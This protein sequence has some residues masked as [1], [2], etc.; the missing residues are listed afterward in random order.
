MTSYS[1]RLLTPIEEQEI[2]P[3]RRVWVS[4]AVEL[5]IVFIIAAALYVATALLGVSLPR[6]FY[7]PFNIALL[8]LPLALWTIFSLL[9]ER[10]AAEP[11]QHLLGVLVIGGLVANA[12]GYPVVTQVFQTE[13]WL[14]L[15]NAFT[16]IVGYTV[17]IGAFQEVLKYL[18][19]RYSIWPQQF[20]TRLDGVAYAAACALGYASVLNLQF[21][22]NNA[23]E[24]AIFAMRVFE[25]I[26]LHTAGAVIVS[27]G[28]SEMRFSTPSPLIL[29]LTVVFAAVINGAYIPLSA[30]LS[31]AGFSLEGSFASPVF[32]FALAGILVG[33]VCFL[34]AFL[35]TRSERQAIEAEGRD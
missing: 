25:N 7:L 11:R 2:Y 21:L 6:A 28:L 23:P 19:I 34:T 20:R 27:F 15:A 5:S 9:R 24:P 26:A 13:R 18:V 31:N 12:I 8:A 4:V 35:Y 29:P 17:S 30:G 14:P 10:A 22:L 16:R 32:G 33:A 1:P 3:Y